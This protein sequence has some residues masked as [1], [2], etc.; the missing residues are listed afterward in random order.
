MGIEPMA[1]RKWSQWNDQI[2]RAERLLI[3]F[4]SP[5][6]NSK[7]LKGHGDMPRPTVVLNF[8]RKHRLPVEVSTLYMSTHCGSSGWNPY[9]EE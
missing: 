6:Y 9:R 8:M 4:C 5:P 3:F 7:W 1:K 2:D